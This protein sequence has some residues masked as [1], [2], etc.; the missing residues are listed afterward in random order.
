MLKRFL[1]VLLL[2]LIANAAIEAQDENEYSS[3]NVFGLNLNTNGGLIG[4]LMFRHSQERKPGR[5]LNLGIE[6]VNIKHPNEV[7]YPGGNSAGNV[8]ILGK[9]NYLFTLR[10]QIGYEFVLF[11]KGKED[12]I[13]VDAIV[14]GGPSIGIV[15][16]Y[17]IQYQDSTQIH[18]IPYS[19]SLQDASI[20][21]PGGFFHG[22]DRIR[23]VPGLHLKTGLS[24][25]FGSFGSGVSGIEA[26]SLI[27]AY[28]QRIDI[29]DI[30]S[31]FPTYNRWFFTSL[32]VNIFFGG[33]R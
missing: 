23:F 19:A 16:P 12:G 13:Q 3:E 28:T 5:Y 8:Y 21:G 18:I 32:Y 7:R 14:N 29:L 24:F 20:V 10:P 9:K 15:K 30:S 1:S 25:E 26:G 27:E 22:F 33:R 6:L 31:S 17:Y 4:G 11:S 2:I